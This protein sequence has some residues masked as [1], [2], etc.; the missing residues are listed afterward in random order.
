LVEIRPRLGTFVA[1]LDLVAIRDMFRVR[2]ALEGEAARQAATRIPDRELS[3]VCSAVRSINAAD[4]KAVVQSGQELRDTIL[5]YC[6]NDVLRR[7]NRSLDDQFARTRKLTAVS[8]EGAVLRHQ[9]HLA[10]AEALLERWPEGAQKA[11]QQHFE[12]SAQTLI[13]NLSRGFAGND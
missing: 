11:V 9:E 2:G 4:P 6:G 1:Q 8:A 13:E 7:L 10:I 12:R 5:R 3:A